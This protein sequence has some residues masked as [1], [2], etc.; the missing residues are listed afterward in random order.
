MTK[1]KIL[2]TFFSIAYT[3]GFAQTNKQVLF[4]SKNKSNVKCYRIPSIITSA[5]G[6]LIAA[7]DERVPNCGDLLYNPDINI[8][9]RTSDDKGKTW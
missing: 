1:K 8:V 7:I 2:L 4:T 3:L 9:I 6:T 5:K